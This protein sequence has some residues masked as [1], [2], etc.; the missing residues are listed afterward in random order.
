MNETGK[1]DD[2]YAFTLKSRSPRC[3]FAIR[4]KMI[5]WLFSLGHVGRLIRRTPSRRHPSVFGVVANAEAGRL[6]ASS[7]AAPASRVPQPMLR[8]PVRRGPRAPTA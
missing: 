3:L 6:V 8:R 4:L 7:S 5:V 1:P 2:A